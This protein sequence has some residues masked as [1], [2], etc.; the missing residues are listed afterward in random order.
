MSISRPLRNCK[1][2]GTLWAICA[3][4][5]LAIAGCGTKPKATLDADDAG[6]VYA[7][8]YS[9][10]GK[11]LASGGAEGEVQLWDALT[12][13]LKRTMPGHPNWVYRAAFSPDGRTLATSTPSDV[14]LWDVGTGE[15]RH[16]LGQDDSGNSWQK[17]TF[18]PDGKRV[19]IVGQY[20]TSYW[21][22]ETG[23]NTTN[24]RDRTVLVAYSPDGKTVAYVQRGFW[25][26]LSLAD[27][28]T[29]EL[30]R[31]IVQEGDPQRV[32]FRAVAFSPDGRLLASMGKQANYEEVVKVWDAETGELKLT[33]K[34]DEK[35][36]GQISSIAFAPDGR[37]VAAAGT[38]KV[39]HIWDA[40]TGELR[41]TIKDTDKVTVVVFSPDGKTLASGNTYEYVKLWDVGDL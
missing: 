24:F 29:G 30:K 3:A 15:L 27:A 41:R 32:N 31:K 16:T 13:E 36:P 37:H 14:R 1:R 5:A 19:A 23:E 2:A 9:P 7:L 4:S 17:F 12:G 38:G 34:A 10:D 26:E 40:R 20:Q 18:T 39:I 35:D 33:L 21:D 8:A 25:N 6:M 22:V 28:E 11:L